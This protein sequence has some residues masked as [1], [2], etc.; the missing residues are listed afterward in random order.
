MKPQK[1][2]YFLPDFDYCKGCGICAYECPAHAIRMVTEEAK[3]H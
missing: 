1:D 3:A 2:G